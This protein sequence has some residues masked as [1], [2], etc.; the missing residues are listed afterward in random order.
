[1]TKGKASQVFLTDK[2]EFY[3]RTDNLTTNPLD[4]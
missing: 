4:D 3:R 1:M 2:S